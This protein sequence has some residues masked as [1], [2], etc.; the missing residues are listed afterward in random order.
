MLSVVN[1]IISHVRTKQISTTEEHR[2]YLSKD[3]ETARKVGVRHGTPLILTIESGLMFE[4]GIKFFLSENGVW[5]T[6]HV[7]VKYIKRQTRE[8]TS[9]ATDSRPL[10]KLKACG[11]FCIRERPQKQFLLLRHPHRWDIPKGHMEK[12]ES[13]LECALRELY[14]E[15]GIREDQLSLCPDFRF[16]HT[17]YPKYKRFPGEKIEKT[18]VIFL[19]KIEKSVKIRTTEHEAFQWVGWNSAHLFSEETIHLLLGK[20]GKYLE[21]IQWTL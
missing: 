8:K 3:I 20:A 14:E 6:D 2:V 7:P 12:N 19:G 15:T 21:S 4:Q 1:F 16:E 5:M 13:E 11:I 18:V 17:Y 10:R 9:D